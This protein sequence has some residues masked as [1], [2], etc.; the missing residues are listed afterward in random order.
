ML[1][2]HSCVKLKSTCQMGLY[3]VWI[4]FSGHHAGLQFHLLSPPL[5]SF[6]SRCPNTPCVV[7]YKLS[8]MLTYLADSMMCQSVSVFHI[9]I[10]LSTLNK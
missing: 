5:L 1:S 3:L 7:G 6:R 4:Y 8:V 2:F 10:L 9:F